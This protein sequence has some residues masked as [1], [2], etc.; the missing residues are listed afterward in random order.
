M[1]MLSPLS[2]DGALLGHRYRL[3]ERI[4]AGSSAEVFRARDELLLRDVA[5]KVF[6]GRHR[7]AADSAGAALPALARPN[8]PNLVTLFDA[9]ADSADSPGRPTRRPTW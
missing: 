5:V 8:H 2:A 1:T 4:G 6:D 3:L 7:A 9:S